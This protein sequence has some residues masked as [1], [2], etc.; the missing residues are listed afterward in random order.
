MCYRRCRFQGPV[1]A[2]M[3]PGVWMFAYRVLPS[4]EKV[5]PVNSLNSGFSAVPMLS[6][7]RAIG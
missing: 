4:G 7:L 3:I 2:S 5:T 1:I 6:S